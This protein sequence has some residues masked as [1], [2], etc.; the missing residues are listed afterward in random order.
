MDNI[1]YN[2]RAAGICISLLTSAINFNVYP[3]WKMEGKYLTKPLRSS[4]SFTLR[5]YLGKKYSPIQHSDYTA[6]AICTWWR[7]TYRGLER[8]SLIRIFG[9]ISEVCIEALFNRGDF[10]V[11]LDSVFEIIRVVLWSYSHLLFLKRDHI[12][13]IQFLHIQ[14]P[15]K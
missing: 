7:R 11:K 13:S 2:I 5:R 3:L 4:Q 9:E 10:L 14:Y 15:N 6:W 1:S 12:I 8:V